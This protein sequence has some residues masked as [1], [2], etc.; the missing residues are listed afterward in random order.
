MTSQQTDNSTPPDQAQQTLELTPQPMWE[1]KQQDHLEDCLLWLLAKL[2]N[3]MSRSALRSRVAREP[4]AWT[5]DDAIEAL[6]SFGFRCH[7]QNA[8]VAPGEHLA[9]AFSGFAAP[10]VYTGNIVDG[11]PEVYNP[12]S[13][14]KPVKQDATSRASWRQRQIYHV[15]H[16][17]R[18]NET[19]AEKPQGRYGHW[20]WGPVMQSKALYW[21][22]GLSALFINIFALVSS[23]FS[24]IVYDRVMPNNA[25]DTLIALV[26][27]VLFVLLGDFI[28]RT[29]RAYFLDLAGLQADMVI[30]DT[31]FEQLV[32]MQM[33]AR[34]G[35][36]GGLASIVRDFESIRDFFTSA[37]LTTFIDIPFA[38][39]F[40]LVI[41]AVGGPLAL[42]PLLVAP[43]VL[44]AS[45]LIQPKLRKLIQLSNEDGHNKHAVIVESLHGIETIKSLGAGSVLRGRWQR[46]VAHQAA[47]G[48]KMRMLSQLANN[49]A[50]LGSQVVW[51]ATVTY[52]FFLIQEGEIGSGAIVACSML[53]GRTISPIAQLAQLL[54]RLNQTLSS[55]KSIDA[56]MNMPREHKRNEAYIQHENFKGAIEFR[57]VHFTYPGQQQPTLNGVSFKI[58]VGEHVAF[59]G[60]IGSGKSTIAAMLM[61]FYAP[62]KGEILIDGIDIRQL[63]TSDL[64]RNIG[65]VLQDIWL[66]SGTV[67]ENIALGADTPTDEQIINAA[68]IAG[69]HD[70]IAPHADGYGMV[71]RERGL[72]LSGGQRQAIAVARALVG[73]PAVLLLDE[74]TSATDMAGER[75]LIERMKL[76]TA[77]KT[78]LLITHRPSM[79]D[80]V[81]RVIVIDAGKVL[82][83]GPKQVIL[84]QPAAN[85]QPA[86]NRPSPAAETS[87]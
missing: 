80:L 68:K 60:R 71:L 36:I 39:I 48:L 75:Q 6:E 62:D 21:Q 37:T 25:V 73:N 18:Q 86:S 23:I 22:V 43:F 32:D 50:N 9:L 30:A 77:N 57:D 42:V 61:A 63:D 44:L 3:P 31:V 65:A 2:G 16:M 58:G 17:L 85:N 24:M 47:I 64:R 78:M 55:Y 52:G 81:D 1:N 14:D 76:A 34:K 38:V 41:F 67:K 5:Q 82:A 19:D 84:N 56:V 74:P 70:F 49:F 35:S 59:I 87:I 33:K 10:Y 72:G 4:G 53:A 27:G 11:I 54:T 13:H 15:E 28:I 8:D 7:L 66:L 69:V 20:F 12:A 26:I 29:L 79:I 51:V 46:S 45:V 83:D 40:I